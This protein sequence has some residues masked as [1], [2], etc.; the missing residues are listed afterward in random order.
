MSSPSSSRQVRPTGE[1]SQTVGTLHQSRICGGLGSWGGMD[2]QLE[3]M[4]RSEGD[5]EVNVRR[6][7][8][9]GPSSHD[10]LLGRCESDSARLGW[11]LSVVYHEWS[12]PLLARARWRQRAQLGRFP[13]HHL[14]SSP[15]S[16]SFMASRPAVATRPAHGQDI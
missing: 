13:F 1:S 7:Q 5:V 11:L 3:R 15:D 2:G 12:R 10:G 4:D 14:A 6:E 16:V 9:H 8:V